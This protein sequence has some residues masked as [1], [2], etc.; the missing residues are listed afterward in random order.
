M[1]YLTLKNYILT[2]SLS[3]Q[4]PHGKIGVNKKFREFLVL[5]LIDKIHIKVYSPK[6]TDQSAPFVTFKV[7]MIFSP[8]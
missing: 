1:K 3:D 5:S 2:Y 6:P 4:I 8:T 7:E